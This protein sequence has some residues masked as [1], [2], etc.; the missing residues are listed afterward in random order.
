MRKQIC[1]KRQIWQIYL[2]Y[3]FE[4]SANF[5]PMHARTSA[6]ITSG[7]SISAI[8]TSAIITSGICSSRISTKAIITSAIYFCMMLLGANK[9]IVWLFTSIHRFLMVL[10][11]IYAVLSRIAFLVL[12]FQGQI[13]NGA[14]PI[15]FCIPVRKS[16][17]LR[18]MRKKG[19]MI[20]Y[21]LFRVVSHMEY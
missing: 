20:D 21:T 15:A 14:T 8:R 2:C 19:S 4:A 1:K 5:W 6:I 10:L 17:S 7:I 3:F 18:G 12:V 13:C 16:S 11:V 9:P